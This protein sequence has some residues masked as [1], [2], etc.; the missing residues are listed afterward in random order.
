MWHIIADTAIK[1]LGYKHKY[2][3][4][5]NMQSLKCRDGRTRAVASLDPQRTPMGAYHACT[6]PAILCLFL[7]HS[8]WKATYFIF[9]PRFL[10][11]LYLI[12]LEAKTCLLCSSSW[13]PTANKKQKMS[14]MFDCIMY[15]KPILWKVMLI[16]VKMT[17]Y[18]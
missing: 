1:N 16:K 7:F 18:F 4:L 2:S 12:R 17:M 11:D 13:W 9:S 8:S 5:N 6:P 14:P 10:L 3:K 15:I